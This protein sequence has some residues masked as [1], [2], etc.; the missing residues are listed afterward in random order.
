LDLLCHF[1]RFGFSIGQNDFSGLPDL[2]SFG[3]FLPRRFER[4]ERHFL[5]IIRQ[6][7]VL[8]FQKF[9]KFSAKNDLFTNLFSVFPSISKLFSLVAVEVGGKCA[10]KSGG[11]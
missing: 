4:N 3:G 8:L 2:L 11:A 5:K 9:E 1:Q 10:T 6:E 7:N